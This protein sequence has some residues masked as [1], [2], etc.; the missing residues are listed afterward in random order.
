MNAATHIAG[1]IVRARPEH[2]DAVAA[3]IA[4]RPH[5]EVHAVA[6]GKIIVVVE[7]ES[8]RALADCMDELRAQPEVLF[9]NL[10]YHQID[11]EP[12]NA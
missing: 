7:A 6:D 10:A 9:V 5:H 1:V 12:E 4:A 11:T 2:A 8:E 3:G